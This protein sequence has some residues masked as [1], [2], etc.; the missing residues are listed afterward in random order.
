MTVIPETCFLDLEL[1][2][3]PCKVCFQALPSQKIA[4][5]SDEII[6]QHK[7]KITEPYYRQLVGKIHGLGK[8]VLL[9]FISTVYSRFFS[10][11]NSLI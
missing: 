9:I 7:I 2:A 4:L 8:M 5:R 10:H 1:A 3:E 6:D 11:S